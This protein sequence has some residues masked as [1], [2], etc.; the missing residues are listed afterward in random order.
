MTVERSLTD[1]REKAV[2]MTIGQAYTEWLTPV[3]QEALAAGCEIVIDHLF[4][5]IADVL[6]G[7]R[8]KVAP[9]WLGEYLPR[10][11]FPKYS[12]IFY[13]QFAV[14]VITVAWKLA[15]P[16]HLPLASVAEELAAW[17]I[18]TEAKG[19]LALESAVEDDDIPDEQAFENFR[20]NYFED[21]DFLFL[22]D[23][24][25]D[26]I[27]ASPVGQTLAMTSLSFEDWF[28]PFSVDPSRIAHPYV[29]GE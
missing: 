12:P 6:N 23:D 8:K 17:A 9:M 19:F 10:R 28:R 25:F 15:Q 14:C 13:K 26:G 7:K 1:G 22:F 11:Y 4:E 20:E 5:D 16:E 24:S 21:E 29:F 2:A 27:D 18:L 3:E